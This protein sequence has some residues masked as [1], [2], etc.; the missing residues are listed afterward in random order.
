MS[1]PQPDHVGDILA[2]LLLGLDHVGI[3]VADLDTALTQW[4]ALGFTVGHREDNPQLAVREAML[5][6]GDTKVQ[7]QLL[8]AL[9]EDSPIARFL[10]R[11]GPGLQQ[12]ALH[13]TDVEQASA[14]VRAAGL[15]VL[16]DT[17][18]QGTAGSRI[19]FIHPRDC[20]GVLVELVEHPELG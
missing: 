3:A 11:S 9:S 5:T 17:A 19:N 16:Y 14:R 4:Q 15:R 2:E 10:A 13:V 20:G 1:H 12:L 18:R 7:I 6:A 8:A